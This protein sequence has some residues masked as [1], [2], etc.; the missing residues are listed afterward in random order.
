MNEHVVVL[1]IPV[2]H[3]NHLCLHHIYPY[4]FAGNIMKFAG[5]SIPEVMCGVVGG[6]YGCLLKCLGWV[7]FVFYSGESSNYWGDSSNICVHLLLCRW[8]VAWSFPVIVG[9]RLEYWGGCSTWLCGFLR[10]VKCCIWDEIGLLDVVGEDVV[11]LTDFPLISQVTSSIL[12][13]AL[14]MR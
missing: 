11:V 9:I 3:C 4:Y 1:F 7:R 14:F 8:Y 6:L 5:S 13:E 12:L 2:D 10:G